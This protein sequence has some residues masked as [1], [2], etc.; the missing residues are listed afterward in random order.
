MTRPKAHNAFAPT[1]QSERSSQNRAIHS[2]LSWRCKTRVSVFFQLYVFNFLFKVIELSLRNPKAPDE[3]ERVKANLNYVAH[4]S[5]YITAFFYVS[6]LFNYS[7]FISSYVF[8]P[9]ILATFSQKENELSNPCCSISLRNI[10]YS[11]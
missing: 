9:A 6:L 11:K 3:M 8:F 1:K 10:F 2:S 7:L 5:D 4:F